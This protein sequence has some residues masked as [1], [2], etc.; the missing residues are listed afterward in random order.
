MVCLVGD[1]KQFD[2]SRINELEEILG[3]SAKA[4]AV[5]SAS[6]SSM[7]KVNSKWK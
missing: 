6:K 7:G 4:Q 3:D 2:D 5:I 1:R